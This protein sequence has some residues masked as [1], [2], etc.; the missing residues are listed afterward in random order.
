MTTLL[1][2]CGRMGGAL[3]RGWL[4]HGLT[5]I[6]VFDPGAEAIDGVGRLETLAAVADLPRPLTVVVAVKPALASKV[7]AEI[8]LLLGADALIV[9][10]MAGI[11]LKAMREAVGERPM[12][13][14]AM[15]NIAVSLGR[16]ATA[17][18]GA[19][20]LGDAHRGICERLLG[21][22]GT[23]AWLPDEAML[24]AATALSG[25]GPAYF[26][27]FAEHL[28]A[29]GIGLGL[30]A[31]VAHRLAAATLAGAGA[32]AAEDPDVAG[33]RAMVT[34][35]G[36]TTAAAIAAFQADDRLRILIA[37]AARA[38][39]TRAGELGG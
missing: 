24:D 7:L 3:L 37:E 12:L 29:A 10:V 22:V 17:A 13:V 32:L 21:S 1:V 20:G 2:G 8:G 25:S 5:D 26:F 35:P 14:R 15:P 27:L 16:G 18:V 31:D 19:E 39:A 36:G 28:A 23:L 9:S 4:A 38:A 33:L 11:P 34:S 6:H 30:P